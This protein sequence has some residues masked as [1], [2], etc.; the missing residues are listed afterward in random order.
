MLSRFLI[1]FL[2]L[3]MLPLPAAFAQPVTPETPRVEVGTLT[4]EVDP[5]P[6]TEGE[7]RALECVFA[8]V[9]KR[10]SETYVGEI[11]QLTAEGGDADKTVMTWQVMA[12][13]SNI[14]VGALS[15]LYESAVSAPGAEGKDTTVYLVG[16]VD[17][18]IALLPL[19]ASADQGANLAGAV[20][21]LELKTVKA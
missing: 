14:D 8:P 4:C 20:A 17:S 10:P 6:A 7:S 12:A 3:A 13:A 2:S 16:G 9:D 19:S 18:A 15:G 21:R 1:V 5:Q 11:E